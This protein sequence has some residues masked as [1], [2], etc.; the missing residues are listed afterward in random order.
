MSV[1]QAAGHK[2]PVAPSA[3]ADSRPAA[4]CK[5]GWLG[6]NPGGAYYWPLAVCW[7]NWVRFSSR[8]W[9]SVAIAWSVLLTCNSARA[10]CR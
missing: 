7:F 5:P 3:A 1:G 10:K 4:R 8:F 2:V 6:A 9:R